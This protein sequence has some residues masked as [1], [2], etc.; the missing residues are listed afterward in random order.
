MAEEAKKT[1]DVISP[2]IKPEKPK[3]KRP[4]Q[5]ILGIV[6]LLPA[7]AMLI[8]TQIIPTV[9][10]IIFSFQDVKLLKGGVFI[11]FDNYV[12]LFEMPAFGDTIIF[13]LILFL[14]RLTAVVIPPLVMALGI[15]SFKGGFRKVLRIFANIPLAI[16]APVPL[17]LGW[18]L[19]LHPYYGF[20]GDLLTFRTPAA[21]RLSLI[22]M[23]GLSFFGLA[24]GI[25]ATAYL[26]ALL[27]G[28]K[29]EGKRSV[30]RSML[31]V[32]LIMVLAVVAI[33]LQDF[34]SVFLTTRGGPMNSTNTFGLLQFS[35]AFVFMN[36]GLGAALTTILILLAG[37]SGFIAVLLLLV[38]RARLFRL[39]EKVKTPLVQK[40]RVLWIILLV[41]LLIAFIVSLL[42]YVL[43]LIIN[44][45]RLGVGD[46]SM[47]DIAKFSL[48]KVLLNTWLPS[49]VTV[50][51]IQ[52]PVA[53]L[54]AL[55]IGGLRPLGKA[56]EWL[57]LLFAPWL[58]FTPMLLD[59]ANYQ[60]VRN[61]E[62]LNTLSGLALP[63]LFNVPLLVI[64][65][66]FF[67]GQREKWDT[68]AEQAPFFKAVI[69]P[70]LPMAALGALLSLVV[71]QQNLL[72]P[73]LVSNHPDK[74]TLPMLLTYNS[75]MF[76]AGIASF[77]VWGIS[78]RI[79][80]ALGMFILLG[81]FQLYYLDRVALRT[82]K[83]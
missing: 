32:G 41:L 18:F 29:Q 46:K 57:L 55:G 13:S 22:L 35:L 20:M 65:T 23:E 69:A 47:L 19:M 33:S 26:A 83:Q 24:C 27:G 15:A 54:A 67:K 50:L 70:V 6:F 74:F 11:G 71:M 59:I 34:D 37:F 38:S 28:V 56:S 8:I 31:I 21:A 62:L 42:P 5:I 75:R 48:T 30:V 10:T 3:N 53:F 60:T 77:E 40:A 81:V 9:K 58:F 76:E 12:K 78:L 72:W 73:T 16:Y 17:A 4:L 63:F 7:L 52:L 39:S 49:L 68:E 45:R 36:F 66:L 64:L 43:V 1:G 79:L 80:A 51:L 14:V 2:E 61:L 44:I 25:G 82:G